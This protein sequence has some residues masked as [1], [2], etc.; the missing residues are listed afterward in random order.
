MGESES[1]N[2]DQLS[3]FAQRREELDPFLLRG[4]LANTLRK[5]GYASIVSPEDGTGPEPP[6]KR[7]PGILAATMLWSFGIS[8]GAVVGLPWYLW[9]LGIVPVLIV[10]V[11]VNNLSGESVV[12]GSLLLVSWVVLG[13]VEAIQ[14][15]FAA[16]AITYLFPLGLGMAYGLTTR[17]L[18][19][20]D[21]QDVALA[22]GGVIRSA[23]LVAPVVLIVLF[24]PALSAD[25]WRVAGD[26]SAGS[27]LI[28]GALSAG[29]LF[30]VV[31]LQLGSQVE[32]MLSQ[33]A[34][35]LSDA[36]ERAEMTRQQ[37]LTGNGHDGE[38][39]MEG[40]TDPMVDSSW[41]VAGEEYAPYLRAAAGETLQAP[42]TGRLALT[43]GAVGILF[44]VYVYLLCSAVVPAGIARE[45]STVD[46]P[47]TSV[48]LLGISIHFHGGPYLSLAALLGLA[49]TATFLSFAL[50]EERFAKALTDALLRDPTDRFLVLALPYMSL[51]EGAI[52]Q[53]RAARQ[54]DGS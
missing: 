51:W 6:K 30:V 48:A 52:E 44:S 1:T 32:T 46:V 29:L 26:L 47:S 2:W 34:E 33:R 5:R 14:G 24:L 12:I 40:M 7:L 22:L 17:V 16:L 25:V 23:P 10:I 37:V 39:L 11:Q 27:L 21:A 35:H 45:W 18:R 19:L 54:P 4:L 50:V 36:S 9:P 42:L 49:A 28:V 31:R 8:L 38:A 41:P 43:I 15:A 20:R 3:E 13:V 53:G